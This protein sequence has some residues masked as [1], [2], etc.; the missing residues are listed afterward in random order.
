MRTSGDVKSL[1]NIDYLFKKNGTSASKIKVI[2]GKIKIVT[3]SG[4]FSGKD[5]KY[6][7]EQINAVHKQYPRLKIPIEFY[8]GSMVFIDKLTF[9]ILECICYYLIHD[10]GHYVQI[11]MNIDVSNDIHIAGIMSSPL[12]L[13]NCTTRGSVKK[14][15]DK[16]KNDLY[17]SHYRKLII[18]ENVEKTNYLG[19][20][21]KDIDTFLKPFGIEEDA[22]DN[23]SN[24]ISELVGNACE[25]GNTD[26]LIDIDVATNY[27]KIIKEQ[28]D[29]YNYYG[30]NIAVVDMSDILLGTGVYNNIISSEIHG[31]NSRYLTVRE[32]F[33]NH[34][35]KF[36]SEYTIDDFCNITTFQHKISGRNTDAETGGTGLTKL[37]KSLEERSDTY[38]CYVISGE[39]AINFYKEMLEYNENQW[40]G[41]NEDKN[42]VSN[43]PGRDNKGNE[44]VTSSLIYM[45]GTAYNLNFVMRGEKI[46]E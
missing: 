14:Y 7:I 36:S 31:K 26:C 34:K 42:Y 11:F 39:R 32:A 43:I 21:Y 20:L 28:N 8:F 1:K 9:V 38:R 44:V 46:D 13:L 30:I 2:N 41:F 16:F 4:I 17:G 18:D 6:I 37:I 24:V 15:P 23:I 5:I 25:H 45:P 19:R 29:G 35:S 40:I 12:K 22:R 27:K 33:N 3:N 10:C